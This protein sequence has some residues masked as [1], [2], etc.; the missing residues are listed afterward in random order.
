MSE[1]FVLRGVLKGHKGWVTSIALIP[2]NKEGE[3]KIISGSRDKSLIIWDLKYSGDLGEYGTPVKSL[4]G[5]SHFIQDVAVSTDGQFALSAS[6]DTTLR[7]WDLSTGNTTKTFLGHTKDVLSVAFNA[8]NTRIVSGSRD[9]TIKL[10]NTIGECK[11]TVPYESKNK[12]YC[13]WV[14][15]VRCSPDSNSPVVVTAG[16]DNLVRVF[17][18]NDMKQLYTLQK[19][20]GFIN[21]VAISP[22][23]SLCASGSK[24]GK[25][26]LWSLKDGKHLHEFDA[27]SSVYCLAFSPSRY[28]LVAGCEKNIQVFDLESKRSISTLN[29]ETDDFHFHPTVAITKTP[30]CT[31]LVW[32]S[33][34]NSL[35]AGYTDNFI[36]VWE[37]NSN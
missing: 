26:N 9:N 37:V 7:L 24:D 28:W 17:N 11:W 33:N 35:Y 23:G 5:H 30:A 19:H 31:A 36:R 22:D 10:W 21:V 8:S 13:Q 6:W 18:L 15:S 4:E 20:T 16:W 2:S 1:T 3:N 12:Q 32:S 25:I 14:T 29:S 34:G 27:Q